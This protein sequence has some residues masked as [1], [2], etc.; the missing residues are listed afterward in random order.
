MCERKR[1]HEERVQMRQPQGLNIEVSSLPAAKKVSIKVTAH[2][3]ISVNKDTSTK[4]RK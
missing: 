3:Q 1:K 4:E 2:A